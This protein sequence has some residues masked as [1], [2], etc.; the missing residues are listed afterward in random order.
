MYTP[1]LPHEA[2]RMGE[3]TGPRL[4]DG[5]SLVPGGDSACALEAV[6]HR[7]HPRRAGAAGREARCGSLRES[8]ER[9]PEARPRPTVGKAGGACHSE[10]SLYCEVRLRD[11]PGTEWTSSE[12]YRSAARCDDRGD[13]R[14]ASGAACPFR[15]GVHRGG[16]SIDGPEGCRRGREGDEGGSRSGHDRGADELLSAAVRATLCQEQGEEGDGGHRG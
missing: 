11:R 4:Q 10:G 5:V 12:A 8:S 14:G 6:A 7:D 1:S 13:R 16:P 3:T 2:S 15:L 9:R